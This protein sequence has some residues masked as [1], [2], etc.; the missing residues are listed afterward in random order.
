MDNLKEK[1]RA[2]YMPVN[3]G[4]PDLFWLESPE[5]QRENFKYKPDQGSGLPVTNGVFDTDVTRWFHT[6]AYGP[7]EPWWPFVHR[8]VF[9]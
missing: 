3:I 5:E 4:P 8:H 6:G 9:M 1:V 2:E 7:A